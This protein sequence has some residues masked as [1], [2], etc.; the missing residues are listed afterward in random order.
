MAISP[1]LVDYIKKS[2]DAGRT[3]YEIKYD[4]VNEGWDEV[5]VE[6]AIREVQTPWQPA[7]PQQPQYGRQQPQA[8]QP[9]QPLRETPPHKEKAPIIGFVFSLVAALVLFLDVIV[10]K[11][12]GWIDVFSSLSAV[13]TSE[14]GIG[15]IVLLL[16][17]AMGICL[18]GVISVKRKATPAG[19]LVII[20]SFISMLTFAG[21]LSGLVGIVAGVVVFLKK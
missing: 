13:D 12:R 14:L 6:L 1:E 15:L 7:Q 19:L 5:D 10:L 20:L 2:L 3:L 4:L 18:G 9:E 16:V 21:L 8:R 17:F 11:S